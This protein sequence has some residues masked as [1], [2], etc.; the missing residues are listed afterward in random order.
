M[1]VHHGRIELTRDE[2]Q[3]IKGLTETREYRHHSV[4]QLTREL[5]HLTIQHM[6]GDTWYRAYQS[7][8]SFVKRDSAP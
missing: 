7:A 3:L 1:I 2:Y 8:L 6:F 4:D 5:A